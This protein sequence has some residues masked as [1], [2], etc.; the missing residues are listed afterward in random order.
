MGITDL[1][2]KRNK[3]GGKKAEVYSYTDLPKQMRV[4]V[5]HIWADLMSEDAHYHGASFLADAHRLYTRELGVFALTMDAQPAVQLAN[6]FMNDAKGEAALDILELTFRIIDREVRGNWQYRGAKMTPDEA[7][8]ELN[9]RLRGHGVGFE[10]A[11]GQLIPINSNYLHSEAVL[12][13]LQLLSNPDF[14]GANDEFLKAH[15]HFRHHR[16]A[17]SLNE[18]L[19]AFESTLK[20]ICARHK[21]R[22]DQRDTASKLIGYVIEKGL[23]APFHQ[24]H[25]AAVRTSLEAGVPTIR[26]KLSGHG[27][28]EADHEVDENIAAYGLHLT[29]ANIVMLVRASDRLL[30]T[31]YP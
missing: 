16:F 7:I 5:A 30:T 20:L 2:S 8:A 12:P 4:Q 13:S 25:L 26:N 24:T 19:K 23:I 17:E 3:P 11:A 1:F 21:W 27:K 6:Y 15:E 29:S 9:A 14:K 28:G 22:Y 31:G 10:F 18:A